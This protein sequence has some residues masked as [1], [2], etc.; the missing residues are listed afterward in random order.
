MHS[1]D[2]A[3]WTA[4]PVAADWGTADDYTLSGIDGVIVGLRGVTYDGTRFV[5]VG[6]VGQ[7]GLILTSP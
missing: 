3:T 6:A 5:A 1:T 2:G 4:A 7:K